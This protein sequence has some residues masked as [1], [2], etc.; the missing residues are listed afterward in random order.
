[1]HNEHR[2]MQ[3]IALSIKAIQNLF[4]LRKRI[5]SYETY[6]YQ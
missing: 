1:M 2:G 5:L 3:L 6:K 4:E